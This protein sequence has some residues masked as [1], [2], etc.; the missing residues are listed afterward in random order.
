MLNRNR[1]RKK[2]LLDLA[3][4][5]IVLA[6]FLLGA[7]ALIVQWTFSVESAVLATV[8]SL[9]LLGSAG[10]FLTTFFLGDEKVAHKAMERLKQETKK[11]KENRLDELDARLVKDRDSRTQ[12]MLRDIRQLAEQFTDSNAVRDV[13]TNLSVEILSN[14]EDLFDNSVK[15]LEKTL[16]LNETAKRIDSRSAR[17]KILEVR[18]RILS[19]VEKSIAT[20]GTMLA[21]LQTM[22]LGDTSNLSKIR[23]QLAEDVITAKKVR[24]RL[25]GI[26]SELDS[27]GLSELRELRKQ[28]EAERVSSNL[29]TL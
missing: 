14:V 26:E 24:E 5:P 16:E 22:D 11:E 29:E 15:Q 2:V 10:L 28:M 27:D 12:V 25:N 18:E 13:N 23:T 4:A 3:T 7:S 8:S 1:L 21:E 17:D 6:P 19:D 20:L 9:S